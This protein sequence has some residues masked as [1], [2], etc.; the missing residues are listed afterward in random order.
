MKVTKMFVYALNYRSEKDSKSESA[1]L[2]IEKKIQ[3]SVKKIAI[4][5]SLN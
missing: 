2:T 1:G 3:K 4:D 5:A